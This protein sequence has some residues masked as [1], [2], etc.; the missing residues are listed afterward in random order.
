M[1]REHK[2]YLVESSVLPRVFKKVVETKRRLQTGKSKTINEAV[3]ETGISRSAY[4]KYKDY[5]FPFY[6]KDKDKIITFTI[7]LR[8]EPGVLH[9]LVGLFS[10]L[11]C[12]IMTINQ[13]IPNNGVATV[14]VSIETGS[15]KTDVD[16]LVKSL[17]N[18]R[19]AIEVKVSGR[20]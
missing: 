9:Q 8:D 18:V 2:F 3:R 1:E 10:K 19:G 13:S 7:V 4:Y 5:V 17:A 14:T 20:E 15:M 11:K 16:A 12:N 6:D